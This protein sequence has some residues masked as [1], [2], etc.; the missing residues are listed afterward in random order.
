MASS[1]SCYACCV[2]T[3][4]GVS[5]LTNFT[6]QA[7]LPNKLR[8]S[9]NT[10]SIGP[11]ALSW[12]PLSAVY[13]AKK[14]LGTFTDLTAVPRFFRNSLKLNQEMVLILL[15]SSSS[16]MSSCTKVQ[17]PKATQLSTNFNLPSSMRVTDF[18]S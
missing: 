1:T 13:G 12:P 16:K 9:L 6:D 18:Q 10:K 5:Q 15:G 11:S 2:L 4:E 3:D 17:L 7:E 8:R 14:T